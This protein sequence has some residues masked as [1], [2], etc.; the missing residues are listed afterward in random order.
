MEVPQVRD[1]SGPATPKP[2]EGRSAC[3]KLAQ[4]CSVLMFRRVLI[5]HAFSRAHRNPLTIHGSRLITCTSYSQTFW[6][7]ISS[8]LTLI[9]L[10]CLFAP[11]I[12]I[13]SFALILHLLLLS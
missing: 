3:P 8:D 11:I 1:E 7:V 9:I 13:L 12:L 6:P 5:F 2:S 10:I 4:S